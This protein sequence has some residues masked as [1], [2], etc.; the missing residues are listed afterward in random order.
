MNYVCEG[1]QPVITSFLVWWARDW[2]GR[3]VRV[4]VRDS[5]RIRVSELLGSD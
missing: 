3:R 2:L 1:F 5:V 4:W